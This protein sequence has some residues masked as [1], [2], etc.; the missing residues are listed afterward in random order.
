MIVDKLK[1]SEYVFANPETGGW[2]FHGTPRRL[3]HIINSP[4]YNATR[5]QARLAEAEA[6]L[7]AHGQGKVLNAGQVHTE[8]MRIVATPLLRKLQEQGH[9]FYVGIT[10]CADV[11]DE[12]LRWLTARSIIK[13]DGTATSQTNRPVLVWKSGAPITMKEARE[14]LQFKTEI[15]FKDMM[16]F[17]SARVEAA[18]QTHYKEGQELALGQ[19]LWRVSGAGGFGLY[20]KW[21]ANKENFGKKVVKVFV[22]YSKKVKELITSGE[23][24]VVV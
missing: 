6:F 3:R 15:V 9:S 16:Y 5:K 24:K 10:G 17:D 20:K 18:V 23:V 21:D 13:S 14:K 8:A 1:D 22:A 4:I 12:D 11:R 2:M 7:R 19:R